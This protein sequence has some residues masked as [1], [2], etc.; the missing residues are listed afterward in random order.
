MTRRRAFV[1]A[2][3]VVITAVCVIANLGGAWYGDPANAL[4]LSVTLLYILCWTALC[5]LPR[6]LNAKLA[7]AVGALTLLSGAVCALYR[8]TEASIV[9]L[10]GFF[11]CSFTGI[12]FYGLRF[13]TNWTRLYEISAV[14]G[15]LWCVLAGVRLNTQ[16]RGGSD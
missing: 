6:S 9:A 10:P 14:V 8:L 2:F 7:L 15:A 11:L 13:F 16:K 5:A 12:P 3:T 1:V 4:Q